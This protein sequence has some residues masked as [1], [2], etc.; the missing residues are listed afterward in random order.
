V[1]LKLPILL[2]TAILGA[3]FL[4]GL[5]LGGSLLKGGWEPQRELSQAELE[6]IA[7]EFL[8]N[9]DAPN[10]GWD[11]AVEAKEIYD[12]KPGGK[13]L[14]VE[15]TT[16]SAGHPDFFLEAI[17][18]HIAVITL[19]MRGEVVSAFCVWSVFH[20]G[21]IWDLLNH[22]WIQQAMI[23]EQQA[24]QIGR[25]FLDGIGYTTGKVLFARL[26][27]KTPNL[28]WHD[29]AEL[30]KPDVQGLRLCWVIRFEQAYRPGHFFEV[31]IDA[32]TGEVVGGIQCR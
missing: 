20:D 2:L 1:R 17:E 7:I 25:H 16:A 27:E 13:V 11:G 26:E 23:S 30:E 8:K 19:D 10:G 12:H 4:G 9:T 14:V 29:L 22:R 15:Y 5:V 6:N 24:I 31:W 21:K 18:H 3:S 32:Y 28:Y